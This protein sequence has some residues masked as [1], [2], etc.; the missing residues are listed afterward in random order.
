[1][2]PIGLDT[3]LKEEQPE[4]IQPSMEVPEEIQDELRCGHYEKLMADDWLF[5]GRW[6]RLDE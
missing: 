2:F 5:Q 6:D 4:H 1:M 3:F